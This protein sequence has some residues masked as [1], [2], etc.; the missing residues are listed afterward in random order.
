MFNRLLATHDDKG[1][2]IARIALG[3]VMFPHGAQ[4]VLGWWGGHG[5]SAT[6]E[7]FSAKMGI[8][9]PLALAAIG[10]EFLGALGLIV[11]L[12]T[13]VAAFGI[14]VTM[15]VA[16]FMHAGNGF[17]MNWFG[18]QEGEGYEYHLLAIGIAAALVVRGAGAVS[19]DGL[20]AK[21]G[22]AA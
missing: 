15:A 22:S 21:R 4:K 9:A 12:G 20:L 1:A 2:L 17:F 7:T 10:A 3:V 6:L 13:R 8:P 5:L 19:L 11:G 16:A 14:G 18:Q